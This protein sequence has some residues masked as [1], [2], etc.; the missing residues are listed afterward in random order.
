M[1][2]KLALGHQEFSEVITKNCIYVDKT[3]II[4]KLITSAEYYFLSRPRR[5]GKSLLAN[6]IKEI[7]LGNKELFKGLW[8]YDKW[9]WEKTYPVIKISFSE[10]G[11]KKLGLEKAID[12]QLDVIAKSYNLTLH[13]TV[14]SLKFKELIEKLSKKA[15]VA[16]IIDEY[17]KPIIDYMDNIPQANE[18]REILKSFYSILK[19]A[20]KHLRFILITGV[21][22]F[23]QVS[24]F[25]DLN[26]LVDIT[27]DEK[28]SQIVGW[29]KDEI[30]NS[31]PDYIKDVTKKYNGVFPDIM[32]E[33]EKWY[34]GYSWDGI[35]RVFNPVSVMNFFDKRVFA[36]YWFST[37]TPTMLMDIIKTRKLTAFDIDNS[38]SSSEILDRYDFEK[39]NFNSLLFQ[40]GYLTIKELDI[41]NGELVLGYPNREIA[42]SFSFNML[43]ECTI[44]KLDETSNLLQKIKQSFN[45]NNIDEFIEYLN[46]LFENIPYLIV[47]KS[48]KYFHSLFFLVIKILGYNIE[49]EVLSIKNRIDAVVKSKNNIYIIE[50]K[51]NQSAKKAIEQI[52]EKKYALKYTDDKRPITLLG[53]NFDTEKKTIDDYLLV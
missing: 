46:I 23:S 37:G 31:F 13:E 22:K 47:D 7:Y 33:M 5:F 30:E 39:I 11:Y 44:G 15:Q 51:I 38:Y 14:N 41:T 34:D 21:S 17:D 35:T 52:K 2:R 28:Y 25:S 12:K 40:T 9:D 20:D 10:M 32:E 49:A 26:N 53:I 16:I 50:F 42:Q 8:I 24:I 48:E 36:N 27:I 19:D 45:N 4:Y 6:T 18:N 1:K 43:S 3:E 29:T